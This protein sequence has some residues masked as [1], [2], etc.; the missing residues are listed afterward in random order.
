MALQN[1][2]SFIASG[3]MKDRKFGFVK[4]FNTSTKKIRKH[5]V[6]I[7]NFSLPEF[8]DFF[9]FSFQSSFSYEDSFRVTRNRLDR[10]RFLRVFFYSFDLAAIRTGYLIRCPFIYTWSVDVV[11]NT[12]THANITTAWF[13]L[14]ACYLMNIKLLIT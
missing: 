8:I 14:N 5:K 12:W 10:G 9:C 13:Y 4:I 1:F 11:V 3:R 7:H 6:R 2:L